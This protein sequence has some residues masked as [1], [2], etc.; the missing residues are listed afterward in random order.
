[1]SNL[2]DRLREEYEADVIGSS[3]TRDLLRDAANELERLQHD[4][5]K[6]IDGRNG[7]AREVERLNKKI[8][9][10][11]RLSDSLRFVARQWEARARELGDMSPIA[12]STAVA[13]ET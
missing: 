2:I 7:E 13:M 9:C 11:K 3:I 4:L 5:E 8:E 10:H 1:M 6:V 12:E